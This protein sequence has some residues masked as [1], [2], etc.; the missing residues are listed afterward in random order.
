MANHVFISYAREDQNFAR[1]LA[2]H[3][4]QRGFEVWMDDRI[5]TG[6]DWWDTIVDNLRDST[7]FAR[8]ADI[9]K[10]AVAA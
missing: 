7:A 8:L 10:E 5:D 6:D 1:K 9:A 4:R 2:D 3:L